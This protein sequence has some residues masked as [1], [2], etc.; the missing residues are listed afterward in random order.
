MIAITSL[1]VRCTAPVSARGAARRRRIGGERCVRRPRR[2]GPGLHV[3]GTFKPASP[4]NASI[5]GPHASC[6]QFLEGWRGVVGHEQF[7]P[8]LVNQDVSGR[9]IEELLDLA[10]AGCISDG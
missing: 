10:H 9:T 7:E 8:L 4:H 2:A 5:E 3:A 1:H 6:V